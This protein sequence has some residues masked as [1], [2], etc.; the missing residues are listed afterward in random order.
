MK[1]EQQ[2]NSISIWYSRSLKLFSRST[3]YTQVAHSNGVQ[4]QSQSDVSMS[5]P[6]LESDLWSMSLTAP[7]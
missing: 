4:G 5:K 7:Q 2:K 6:T 3:E 1:E